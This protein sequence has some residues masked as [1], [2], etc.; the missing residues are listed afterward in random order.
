MGTHSQRL[1]ITPCLTSSVQDHPSQ[2]QSK[3]TCQ[4]PGDPLSH[5][6]GTQGRHRA[7]VILHRTG[8]FLHFLKPNQQTLREPHTVIPHFRHLIS[9]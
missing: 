5:T 3:D 8:E 6:H 7:L 4:Q 2:W 1:P 9:Y